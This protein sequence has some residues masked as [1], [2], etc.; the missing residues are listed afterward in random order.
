MRLIELRE[1]SKKT[2]LEVA[3]DLKIHPVTYNNYE[4]N[5]AK[6]SINTLIKLADYYG[7]SVDYLIGHNYYN[8]FS[9]LTKDE[10]E[11]LTVYREM[12]EDNKQIYYQEGRGI[13][14]AQGLKN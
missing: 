10:K 9:Y 4:K 7:I 1:Q 8:D 6:P 12:T 14:L 3:K 13:L 2:Q 11:I 5:K